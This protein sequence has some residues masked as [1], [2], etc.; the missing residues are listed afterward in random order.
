MS[1][2]TAAGICVPA[3]SSI[4]TFDQWVEE[5]GANPG[6][7]SVSST[8]SGSL[9]SNV[10]VFLRDKLGLDFKLANYKG[11]GPSVRAVIAQ[12]VDFGCMGVTPQV[13]FMQAGELRCLAAFTPEDWE[14]AGTV[15]PSIANFVDDPVLTK[16][17]P[18]TNIHGIALAKGAPE[19]IL[20]SI[21]AAFAT[22]MA[23]P[24][25]DQ[26]YNDNAF[27]AFRA[28]RDEANDLMGQRTAL[29]AYIVEEVLGTA[30]KTRDE[31]DI[32]KI[33]EG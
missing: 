7:Y 26:L 11:G 16:T 30:V 14:T 2:G 18:W 32:P 4:E 29:Q 33:E 28:G 23:D 15:I 31:L 22:A 27:F 24:S 20:T 1:G 9:W 21:D 10:A 5:I 6:K 19:E 12:E 13:N 17:L 3:S 8:P 25:M